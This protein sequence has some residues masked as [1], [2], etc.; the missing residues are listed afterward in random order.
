MRLYRLFFVLSIAFILVSGCSSKQS[1]V[2]ESVNSLDTVIEKTDEKQE[3]K[4]EV[5]ELIINHEIVF[6]D[7]KT[8][9][10][11]GI[12]YY[13]LIDPVNLSSDSFKN[14]IK[15]LI[16]RI[17]SEKG[18]KISI[19]IYDQYEALESVYNENTNPSSFT[20]FD[21]KVYDNQVLHNIAVYDG[22]LETSPNY[23]SLIFFPGA[24]TGYPTVSKYYED[25][26]FDG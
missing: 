14:E 5:I 13:V 16:K 9:Y 1:S 12:I 3:E 22:E 20:G 25:I 18:N 11:G 10:D 23:N 8:R 2:K 21:Q 6:E 4:K 19:D 15:S 24:S 7:K 26:P 17:V